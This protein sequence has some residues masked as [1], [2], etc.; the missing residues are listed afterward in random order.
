[1]PLA[2]IGLGK[3]GFDGAHACTLDFHGGEPVVEVDRSG[4]SHNL[5]TSAKTS[6][7]LVKLVALEDLTGSDA[8]RKPLE[9]G[10]PGIQALL[11]GTPPQ[12]LLVDVRRPEEADRLRG[13]LSVTRPYEFVQAVDEDVFG[14]EDERRLPRREPDLRDLLG[15]C[16]KTCGCFDQ[17]V[18]LGINPVHPL[19]TKPKLRETLVDRRPVREIQIDVTGR[20]RAASPELDCNTSNHDRAEAELANDVVDESCDGELAFGLVFEPKYSFELRTPL[21]H[22]PMLSQR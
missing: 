2:T 1:V 3:P 6:C 22:G 15:G 16:R 21:G 5:E 7:D 18:V 11:V 17:D 4:H 9:L 8:F 14:R 19:T 12:T 10:Q 13:N 20:V